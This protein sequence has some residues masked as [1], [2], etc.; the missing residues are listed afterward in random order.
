M[1]AAP[2]GPSRPSVRDVA[3]TL[4][5]PQDAVVLL[6]EVLRGR[7]VRFA[8]VGADG[9]RFRYRSVSDGRVSLRTTGT[10]APFAGHLAPERQY[11]LAW[12]VEGGTVVDPG[13]PGEVTML[14]SVPIAFPADR[15][16]AVECVAGTLHSVHFG[17]D[18]LEAVA[19][20]GT[21]AAPR[22]LSLP[23]TVDPERLGALQ[24]VVRALAPALLDRSTVGESRDALDLLLAEAVLAA[25]EPMPDGHVPGPRA[26]S[27]ERAKTF[28]HARFDRQLTVPEIAGAADVS[29]RTLQETFQRHEGCTPMAFL[30]EIRLEKARL[31]LQLADP[32]TSSVAAVAI[33]CGFRHMG[34]FSGAY[35]EEFG[36]YP[37]ET[38]RHRV[39]TAVR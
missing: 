5:A 9:F 34:R 16:F 6:R 30:R 7:D 25:F 21:D 27:V 12:T 20:R 22:P 11:V 32:D 33:S 10:T 3:R 35:R 36:E 17:A 23:V 31:G 28:M 2:N 37:G 18:Y 39:P 8:D 26:T 1:N 4:S 38:L 24:D 14:P 19:A 15:E 13:R 29:V